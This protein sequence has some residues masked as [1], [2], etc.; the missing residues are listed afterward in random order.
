MGLE[1]KG[2]DCTNHIGPILIDMDQKTFNL[3]GI[4]VNITDHQNK[5]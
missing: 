2:K 4:F 1:S 5:A 3:N